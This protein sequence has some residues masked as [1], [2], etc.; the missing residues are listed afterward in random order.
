MLSSGS[1]VQQAGS[2]E[3]WVT[4]PSCSKHFN[5]SHLFYTPKFAHVKLHCP[6]CGHE[7][8]KAESLKTW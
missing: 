7:F 2:K 6:W 8:D 4:C 3:L 5:V 1:T